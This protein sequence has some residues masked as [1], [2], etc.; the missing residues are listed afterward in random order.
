[1]PGH[2]AADET[3]VPAAIATLDAGG[4]RQARRGAVGKQQAVRLHGGKAAGAMQFLALPERTV[5]QADARGV[6]HPGCRRMMDCG[7][8]GAGGSEKQDRCQGG[9]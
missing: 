1:M 2:V 7:I 5:E 8:P 6:Q 3:V 9:E 4:L